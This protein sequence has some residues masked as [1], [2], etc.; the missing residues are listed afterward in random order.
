M[1]PGEEIAH[2]SHGDATVFPFVSENAK[3]RREK[4]IVSELIDQD[5]PEHDW[6]GC[7]VAEPMG[8]RAIKKIDYRA[9]ESPDR[10][11]ES[12]ITEISR[13][14]SPV[15]KKQNQKNLGKNR[16]GDHGRGE[17][18]YDSVRLLKLRQMPKGIGCRAVRIKAN[19]QR[20]HDRLNEERRFRVRLSGFPADH[21][22]RSRLWHRRSA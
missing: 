1:R 11:R 2:R 10:D 21:E 14:R 5:F 7:D 6:K 13:M 12:K 18:E 4:N 8:F 19:R 20:E 15:L 3:R 17:N 22:R 9:V 16:T